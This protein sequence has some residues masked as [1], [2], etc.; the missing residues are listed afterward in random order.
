MLAPTSSF[1]RRIF[2]IFFKTPPVFEVS[3]H[4]RIDN[5]IYSTLILCYDSCRF[6]ITSYS[7]VV[8]DDN[9]YQHSWCEPETI[10][11]VVASLQKVWIVLRTLS[12]CVLRENAYLVKDPDDDDDEGTLGKTGKN[13]LNRYVGR[14]FNTN[15]S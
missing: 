9:S 5:A 15:K 11:L 13:M 12:T 8:D 1:R 7:L 10:R 2:I 14:K 6:E 4:V 3:L